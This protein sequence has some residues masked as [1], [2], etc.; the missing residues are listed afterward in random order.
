MKQTEW[1]ETTKVKWDEK[2]ADWH[3]KS[4]NMWEE[5]S[6]KDICSFVEKHV[7]A[8][9]YVAD[10]GCGDGYGAYKLAE[11]GFRVTGVDL[12][13][14]MVEL[15]S[16]NQHECLAFRQGDLQD[17]PF[18]AGEL[19][20]IMAINSLEW[21]EKPSDVL[22]EIKRVLKP[23][24][25]ACVA[26]LGPTAGPRANS[27]GRLSG[28][29]VI[30]NTM[31]PWE[32]KQ[33]ANQSGFETIDEL[34]VYKSGVSDDLTASLPKELKQALTFITVFMLCKK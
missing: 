32:F 28:E 24:G 19:D 11:R 29:P 1:N 23:S 27:Y 9:S 31:M 10:L 3:A 4:I 8:S 20:A 21:T 33:L 14:K 2:A 13:E 7:E 17:L 5:G 18:Q 25:K 15:A 26:I 6:R 30:M 12:S 34:Y 16:K 22:E